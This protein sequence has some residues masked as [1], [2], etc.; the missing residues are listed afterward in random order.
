MFC[1]VDKSERKSLSYKACPNLGLWSNNDFSDKTIINESGIYLLIMNSQMPNAKQHKNI[2]QAIDCA[3][4]RSRKFGR[5]QK[6]LPNFGEMSLVFM[7][8][9]L[10]T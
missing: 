9:T 7:L 6:D 3:K 2:I 10:S 1:D 5:L 8:C 4:Y